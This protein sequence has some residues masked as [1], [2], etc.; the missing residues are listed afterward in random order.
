M[1]HLARLLAG[2]AMCINATSTLS[3]DA[4]MLD[5]PVIF[6]AFDGS[7]ALSYEKSARRGLD[8][9]H[10]A[11]LVSLGGVRVARSFRDLESHI[12]AYLCDPSLEHEGRMLSVAQECG[13]LDGQAAERVASTLLRLV[14]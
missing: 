9:I 10:I 6:I 2:C 5:R 7:G 8:Y 12:N 13:P 3:L 14:H 1:Y 11:K 4:C